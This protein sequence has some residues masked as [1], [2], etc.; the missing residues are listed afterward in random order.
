MDGVSA[1][2]GI[3]GLVV[4]VIHAARILFDDINSILGAPET[5]TL[6]RQDL[7]SLKKTLAAL[8]TVP[9]VDLDLLGPKV[10]IEIKSALNLCN[11]ACV[12]F[13]ADLRRWTRNLDDGKLLW[14]EKV[15][16]GFFK[17]KRINALSAQLQ[18]WKLTIDQVVN[19]ATLHSSL[20]N[21]HI[22]K[23]IQ[24]TIAAQEMQLKQVITELDN[25]RTRLESEL[26][27]TITSPLPEDTEE[28]HVDQTRVVE[29]LYQQGMALRCP[30]DALEKA[31]LK[32]ENHTGVKVTNVT[33]DHT[34]KVLAGL[35]NTEGKYTTVDVTIDNIKVSNGGKIVAGVVEG[36]KIDF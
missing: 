5:I 4:P 33:V 35:I 22:S 31:L 27:E 13:S 9:P 25:S 30:H 21:T 17:Q 26:A 32:T 29:E 34:G 14:L 7:E 8:D 24:K 3:V 2:A 1:A 28:N 16:I 23:D 19:M 18:N 12:K 15:K 20:R 11:H 6:I 36:V 10:I